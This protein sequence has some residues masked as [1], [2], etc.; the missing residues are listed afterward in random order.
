MTFKGYDPSTLPEA[1]TVNIIAMGNA[2]YMDEVKDIPGYDVTGEDAAKICDLWRRL[3][4]KERM[5]CFDG[6]HGLRFIRNGEIILEASICYMCNA[7]AVLGGPG[8]RF[9]GQS[10]VAKELASL[11]E[12]LSA[13][14]KY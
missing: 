3:P 6:R 11:L 1:D 8:G 10:P 14:W 2:D 12:H 13:R 7:I 9:D 4:P 5:R